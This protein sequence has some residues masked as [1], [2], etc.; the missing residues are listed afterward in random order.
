MNVELSP[1]RLFEIVLEEAL[2]DGSVEDGEFEKVEQVKELLGITAE[3]H[4]DAFKKVKARVDA[5]TKSDRGMD[6]VLVY[7]KCLI[8]AAA[9]GKITEDETEKLTAIRDLFSIT[10][11]E[12]K[13]SMIK[14]KQWLAEKRA[15][16]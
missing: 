10:A 15:A 4:R 13:T 8:V 9:D 16:K 6:R 5:S 11:E 1:E 3:Q 7:Q 14:V 12:H 2:R